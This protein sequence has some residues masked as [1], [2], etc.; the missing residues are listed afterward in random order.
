MIRPAG[1]P[2]VL[3][4]GGGTGGHLFPGVAVAERLVRRMP[5]ANVLLAATSR[6]AVARHF[7]ACPLETVDIESPRLPGRALDVPGFGVRMARAIQRSYS[8]LRE[9]EPDI[10][11]G[12]GG[13]GSVAPVLAACAR[14]TPAIVL[15]QNAKPG[16]AT[17][18]L[19]RF[20]AV[21]AASFPGLWQA[22]YRGRAV[23]TG[24]PIRERVLAT[25]RCPSDFGFDPGVPTLGVLGGSL[26]ARG[27]NWRVAAGAAALAAAAGAAFQVVHA[28]GSE[29]DADVASRAWAQAGVRALVRP[30]FVDMGA[31]YGTCDAL[32]C[33]SGG[34]TVAE[35]AALGLP[36]VFVPYPHHADGHQRANAAELVAQGAATVVE[37]SELTPEA[38]AAHAA[39]LLRDPA[40]RA[41]RARRAREAGRPRAADLVVDLILQLTGLVDVDAPAAAAVGQEVAL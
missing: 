41:E 12:L 17:R 29:E 2:K 9:E 16:K 23:L 37:E 33:R 8:F 34:T 40:L 6:D 28:T 38:L 39:P 24:N 15:E 7:A 27:L 21:A 3:M 35:V 1:V 20:G 31:L 5:G 10:V 11:I 22:G 26:G 4:A 14:R 32:V 19:G 18:F 36:A 13:Y 25:R 30:F